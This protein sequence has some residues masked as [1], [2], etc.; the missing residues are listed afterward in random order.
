MIKFSRRSLLAAG[1][2]MLMMAGIGL[3][4]PAKAQE[5]IKIGFSMALTGGLASNGKAALAAMQI[6]EEEVNGR[7][8]LIGRPVKL[9][10]YDD[11]SNGATVPGIVT[12]LLDVD[13]VDLLLSGYSTAA[14]APAMPI[15]VQKKMV[16]LTLLGF[17]MNSEF[18]YD[19]YFSMIPAGSDA[20][21]DFSKGFLEVAATMNPKPKTIAVINLDA[22]FP[23][24]ASDGLKDNLKKYD[25]KVVYDQ[26]YPP[27]T[28]DFLP[29]IRAVAAAKPDLVYFVSYPVDSAGLIRA[30]REVGL[31]AMMVGGGMVGPQ[32]GSFKTMMGPALNN[33]VIWDTYVP[34]KTLDFPG[35]QEFLAKYQPRSQGLDPLGFYVPPLAYANMQVLEQAVT[36]VGKIDQGALAEFMHANTFSTVLGDVKFDK[37]GEW[38]Q[39]RL[40]LVQYQ[41]INGNGLDQFKKP[42]TQ[43]ILYPPQY[44]SGDLIYPFE[45]KR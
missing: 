43:P 1:S 26:S 36:K 44:K 30:I 8:G 3:S 40:L 21:R 34:E 45:A 24:R 2:A 38:S 15:V 14:I 23:K 39:E 42:G 18:K 17:N 11:Q 22:E 35:I 28:V 19:R 4:T 33:M 6:W 9:V 32:I 10:Y 27:T 16:F 7:G 25:L 20:N 13:K 31:K 41:N 12:K 37:M 29:I 5:P